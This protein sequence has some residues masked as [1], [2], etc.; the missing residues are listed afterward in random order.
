MR[1]DGDLPLL[2]GK[3]WREETNRRVKRGCRIDYLL[4]V[5]EQTIL[6]QGF[7]DRFGWGGYFG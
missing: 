6:V 5:I 4:Q 7:E 1:E 2:D 3:E